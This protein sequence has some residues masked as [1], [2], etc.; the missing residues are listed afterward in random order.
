MAYLDDPAVTS[1]PDG[2]YTI[3]GGPGDPRTEDGGDW[4]LRDTSTGWQATHQFD[5]FEV[6]FATAEDAAQA[7]LGDPAGVRLWGQ[8]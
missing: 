1:N 7:A 2:T 8:Q 3:A 5:G 6:R 4:T